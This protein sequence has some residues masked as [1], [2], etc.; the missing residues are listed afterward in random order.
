MDRVRIAI[1][2]VGWWGTTGHLA[3]LS[4]DP[5]AEVVAVYSRTAAKAQAQAQRYGVPRWYDNVER[6]LDECSLDAVVV[7]T[8]PNVHYA[9]AKLALERGLHTLVEKPFMLQAAHARELAEM[10]N[11]RGLLLSVAHPFLFSPTIMR[12]RELVRD[13]VGTVVAVNALFAQRVIDLYRGD[14]GGLLRAW[15]GRAE[16]QPPNAS[17]YADPAV[18]GGGEGHTQAS[19]LVGTLLWVTGLR[20]QE[21]F[22]YMENADTQV[23]VVDALALRFEG[24][25]VGTLLTNGHL[26]AGVHTHDLTVYGQEGVVRLAWDNAGGHAALL[27]DGACEPIP[28]QGG[29]HTAEVPCNFCRAILGQE[30]LRTPASLAVDEVAILDAAYR[31]AASGAPARTDA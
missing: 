16:F 2:G 25:A 3:P 22:A 17:S 6:M 14:P 5:A 27:L 13:R 24:G 31:S 23:D 9:Q 1:I 12:A 7:A 28:L 30:E 19:H 10:A 15:Q 11:E 4:Q 21:V 29:S 26:P 18:V 20:P 8:T